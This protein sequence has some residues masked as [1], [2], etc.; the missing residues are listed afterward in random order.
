MIRR[1]PRSTRTDTLCPDTTLFRSGSA[2]LDEAAGPRNAVAQISALV[3]R[4]ELAGLSRELPLLEVESTGAADNTSQAITPIDNPVLS[5][6]LAPFELSALVDEG[7][8]V[9][10]L[11]AGLG[12]LQVLDGILGLDGAAIDLG[13]SALLGDAGATRGVGVDAQIGRAHV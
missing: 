9:S 12:Q 10:T 8:A 7:G 11:S 1:P 13:N 2:N 3:L 5:G 6:V 4:A